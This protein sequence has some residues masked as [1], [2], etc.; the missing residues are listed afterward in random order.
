MT[1]A[2]FP[3]PVPNAESREFWEGCQRGELLVQ[4]CSSCQKL[5]YFPR[6]ACPRCGS[7]EYTWH[8][9]SGKGTLYSYAIIHPPTL[10]A[11]KDKVPYPVILV[12][13]AEGVRMVSNI[14]DCKNEELRIGMPLEVVFEKINEGLTL[15]KFRPARQR[16]S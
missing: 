6:P 13:L 4:R 8:K 1:M 7:E 5:R 11:F 2:P 3:T 12:E 10:P 15:P 16:P 14:V 9:A